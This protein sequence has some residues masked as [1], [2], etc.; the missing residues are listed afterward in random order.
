MLERLTPRVPSVFVAG[1]RIAHDGAVLFEHLDLALPAGS[2]TGLLGPS[3]VGKT[4]LL[5]F[6]LGLAV[7]DDAG[8]RVTCDDG[9]TVAGRAAYMA[10]RD[11]LLPWL[12]GRDN[13]MLGSRLRGEP[14]GDAERHR[15]AA[16][17][18]AVG[19]EGSADARPDT[20]SGGMRQRVALARTL[21]ENRPIVLMDEPFSAV[22]A[23]TRVR[24]QNLAVR[25]L[26][27]RTVMLVTH[28]PLEALRLADRILVMSGRPARLGAPLEPAAPPPRAVDDPEVLELQGE[29]LRR[30]AEAHE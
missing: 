20:L 10:Q 29:L 30:L 5:R 25:L 2:W 17:L 16:L 12:S 28:D 4:A 15:A 26:A 1:A 23:I 6:L 11:L 19:L 27:G 3:G 24:L 14:I 8:G 13:V 7:G 21:M 18:E 9:E 22:D